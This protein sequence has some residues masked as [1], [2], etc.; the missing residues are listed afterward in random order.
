MLGR[1]NYLASVVSL[2]TPA[3]Q[4]SKIHLENH[5]DDNLDHAY[6]TDF[7]TN[8][9]YLS[10]SWWLLH[11]GCIDLMHKVQEAVKEVFGA[12]NP[13]EEMTLE[14]LSNLTL[15]VRKKVEGATEEERRYI[16]SVYVV[17]FVKR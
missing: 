5:D 17:C 11:R 8:R 3:A 15:E 14:Q 4:E 10:F 2:A 16:K 9:R 1:R 7:E 6:G 12:V 13:R